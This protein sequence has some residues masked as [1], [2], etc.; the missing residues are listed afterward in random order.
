MKNL[1]EKNNSLGV[2]ASA[3]APIGGF[4]LVDFSILQLQ[5]CL[6]PLS[7]LRPVLAYSCLFTINSSSLFPTSIPSSLFLVSPAILSTPSTLCH[8]F[9]LFLC[10]KLTLQCS[11]L[12]SPRPDHLRSCCPS[13]HPDSPCHFPSPPCALP[14]AGW[15]KG[16]KSKHVHSK[17][18]FSSLCQISLC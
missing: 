4:Q 6:V 7:S 12:L 17:N 11:R 18:I 1:M 10:P 3:L 14:W 2:F 15:L 9:P 13:L 5:A 16:G 8:H